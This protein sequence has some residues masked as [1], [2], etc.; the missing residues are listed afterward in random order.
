M[1]THAPYTPRPA[2]R[3]KTGWS[4]VG[5]GSGAC[6]TSQLRCVAPLFWRLDAQTPSSSDSEWRPKSPASVRVAGGAALTSQL[7]LLDGKKP[8]SRTS[9]KRRQSPRM[10]ESAP[11][12]KRV[13]S[14]SRRPLVSCEE[15]TG[16]PA[17]LPPKRLVQLIPPS[18][19]LHVQV[20]LSTPR[21]GKKGPS[22][23]GRN[24]KT[25][26]VI[27]SARTPLFFFSPSPCTFFLCSL[28]QGFFFSHFLRQQFLIHLRGTRFDRSCFIECPHD[29]PE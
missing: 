5:Q 18:Q 17:A 6:G 9:T 27:T 23:P 2:L 13:Q 3:G 28:L 16:T 25:H 22:Q 12:R 21:V 15:P 11:V 1:T 4:G 24:S 19:L 10:T 29:S 14:P 8:R 26:A 20:I 7:C